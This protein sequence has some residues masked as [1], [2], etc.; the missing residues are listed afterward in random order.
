MID[1]AQKNV[2]VVGL[3]VTGIAAA[4][5][6]KNR[7]AAV[8]ATDQA[9][10]SELG[11]K[12]REFSA[13]GIPLELGGHRSETFNRADLIVLS[14]G[15]SHT[16]A[17]VL[18]ARDRG[19][20]VMGE[21]ELASR[22]IRQPV[23]A[24]TGT[25][26]KTTTTELLGDMLERSGLNVFVGGNIGNPLID[27]AGGKQ[28]ADVIVAEISSFQLDT[29]ATFKPH[30]GVL[31][32]ITADH[33]DR[34]PDFE[35]YAASKIR[36]FEN[37]Q[38][39]DVAVL[40]GADPLVR[41]L[42]QKMTSRILIYPN[43]E[44][45]EIGARLID[46]DIELDPDAISGTA[47]EIRNPH[48]A[49][50]NQFALNLSGFKLAGRHNRENACAASLAAL[51]AGGRPQAIQDTLNQYRGS[52]HRMEYIATIADIDFYNDSKATN[53]AA[54][55][56]AVECFDKPV[57]LIMGGLDKGSDFKELRDI[58]TRH[59]KKLF[60]LGQAA[61]LIR[62]AL[63]DTVPTATATSMTAAVSQAYRDSSAGDV[64]LLSP[65]C[66]SFDMYDNYAQRGNDF[67]ESVTKLKPKNPA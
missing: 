24:M 19:V 59:V 21:I 43:P 1:V 14:P 23:A 62:R 9:S 17:P 10:A 65:G 60:L 30:I 51:A 35:A 37:Q 47:S 36:L 66:A 42:T 38:A 46:R 15:V 27:Y 16:I 55:M 32:N 49:I 39:D 4:R 40:N 67:K 41:S 18:Q 44:G 6:L 45:E 2:V 54:V 7:G 13:L 48:A 20:P 25:N 57:V 52:A 56:R 5:F 28:E 50:R 34:Y 63:D 11:S 53:V 33:L 61:D 8:V 31:L 64:V 22:Y 58:F 3:G 12:V 29:T 26:G